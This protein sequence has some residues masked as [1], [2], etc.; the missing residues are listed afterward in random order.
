[1]MEPGAPGIA[2]G[3]I[4]YPVIPWFGVMC[5]GY[6]LG[7]V[8]LQPAEQRRRSV[9]IL[10]ASAIAL[11]LAIR[12]FNAFG[13]PAPWRAQQTGVATALSFFN[14]SKYPPS[15]LYV[16]ITLGVSLSICVALERL[17]AWPSQVLLAFGRTPLATYLLHIYVVHGLACVVGIASGLS[18]GDFARFLEINFF[19]RSAHLAQV[20]W[21][22][23]LG[24]VYVVWLAV[25]AALYPV[26]A[27]M[28]RLKRERRDWWLSYV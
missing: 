18:A 4:F 22:F 16:L 24:V 6:G 27:W 2:P 5:L 3:L 1:M 13:D 8:F 20:G 17:R 28:A 21:G 23:N 19:S 10:A 7:G 26:S 11:F 14:V 15:L 9:L 25:L 12:A